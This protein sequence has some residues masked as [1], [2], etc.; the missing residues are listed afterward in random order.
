MLPQ[1]NNGRLE[2]SFMHHKTAEAVAKDYLPRSHTAVTVPTTPETE[3]LLTLWTDDAWPTFVEGF[4]PDQSVPYLFI[5]PG[6]GTKI[7]TKQWRKMFMNWQG[8]MGVPADKIITPRNIRH[9]WITT[10]KGGIL[11]PDAPVPNIAGMAAVRAP[12][13]SGD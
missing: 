13:S 3:E 9:I 8:E 7:D 1:N 11:P 4:C 12:G 6:T 5:H 2:F 10:A